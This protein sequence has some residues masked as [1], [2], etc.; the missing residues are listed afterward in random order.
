MFGSLVRSALQHSARMAAFLS[1]VAASALAAQ[2]Q[3]MFS[4]P[5]QVSP[6]ITA[7]GEPQ[8]AI[9]PGGNVNV[10]WSAQTGSATS[11]FFSRSTDGG[12]TFS[13]PLKISTDSGISSF[14][15]IALDASGNIDVIWNDN[16]PGYTA[17]FFS[18][19]TDGGA[20]FSSP[21]NISA[22]AGGFLN[23]IRSEIAVDLNGNINVGWF[24]SGGNIVFT[25]S[26]DGGASFSAPVTVGTGIVSPAVVVDHTG[27][28]LLLW[29]AAVSGHNPFDVFFTRSADGGVTFSSPK[30]ISNLPDGSAYEQI[31][32][33]PDGTIDVVWNSNCQNAG[34]FTCP[35]GPSSA[36]W[37]AQSKDN[38][39]T[40]SSPANLSN[41]TGAGIS[42]VKMAIESTGKIDVLWPGGVSTTVNGFLTSSSDGGATFST[43]RQVITG[44]ANQLAVDSTGNISVSA[45]DPANVYVARST[46]G[47]ANFSTTNISNNNSSGGVAQIEVRM[48]TDST[49]NVAV[50]WPNYN[51][52]T[53][54]WNVVFSR[55]SALSLSS[56]GLSV[57]SV[58]GG[59]SPTG[60]VT[61]NGAAPA[62][63][64]VVSL[65]SSNPAVSVPAT[66]T[67]PQGGT[68]ASFTMNTSPVAT[69]TTATVSVSFG[70]VTQTTSL[71]VLP[72][73][74]ASVTLSQSSVQ[75]GSSST[76]TV[77]LSG[78]APAGGSVVALSSSN[79]SA[80][81]VPSSVTVAAGFT[82]ATFP[83]S[84]EQ[85]L[86]PK[87]TTVSASFSGVTLTSNLAVN[88]RGS[89][90]SQ[91]CSV[92][93]RHKPMPGQ[94]TPWQ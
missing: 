7:P 45:N 55:G 54:Q 50:V 4:S 1:I 83:V 82:N 59:A 57:A 8:I 42:T 70:G 21:T 73:V 28:V 68:S 75:G 39:T 87:G 90:P 27:N 18:R 78:P 62:G 89:V 61:M 17:V 66:V 15:Q 67:I 20:T 12:A 92:I 44:F 76:G 34:A 85:S 24:A 49:G 80:A 38:G 94:S 23:Q 2:A 13:T 16:S 26:S 69:A 29:E 5:M 46:D 41:G 33:A 6:G 25:R 60:T 43:P 64:T 10:V 53:F 84:T 71:T 79:T 86:C 77:T 9:D 65:S 58:T 48:V 35:A 40:F 56:L 72:P 93:G 32:V 3:V 51:F 37:F 14:P 19:S 63:G 47:G 36:V 74:L 31:A 88:A 52:N 91:A 11:I 81:T 22:P 30:D